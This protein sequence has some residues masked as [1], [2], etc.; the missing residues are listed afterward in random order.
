MIRRLPNPLLACQAFK[1]RLSLTTT[2]VT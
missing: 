2:T 1:Q